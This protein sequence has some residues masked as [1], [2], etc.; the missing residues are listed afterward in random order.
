MFRVFHS[1][2]VAAETRGEASRKE[3]QVATS[4][5]VKTEEGFIG[6]KDLGFRLSGVVGL[7]L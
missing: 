2:A 3:E 6:G 4:A 7:D 5:E 1:S